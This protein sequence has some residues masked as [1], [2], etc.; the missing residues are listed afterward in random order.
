MENEEITVA[1][2]RSYSKAQSKTAKYKGIENRVNFCPVI[3]K[4]SPKAIAFAW[5]VGIGNSTGIGFG[6]L[7]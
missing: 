7:Q 4:G 3:L 5:D 2:D 1:F 6:A